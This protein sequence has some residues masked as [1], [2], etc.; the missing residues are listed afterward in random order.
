MAK[1]T[2]TTKT[3]LPT[4]V[5][6]STKTTKKTTPVVSE[7]TAERRRWAKYEAEVGF[8]RDGSLWG[9]G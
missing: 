3:A 9:C 1:T 7:R 6:S 4:K 8:D 5:A 2:K